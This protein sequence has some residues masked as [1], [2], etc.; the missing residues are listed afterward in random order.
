[1][2][3][4]I[5]LDDISVPDGRLIQAGLSHFGFYSGTM[6]GKPGPKTKDAYARYTRAQ[7]PACGESQPEPQ[8]PGMLLKY[9]NTVMDELTFPGN[10]A[11]G[12]KGR[13]A[14]RVQEWVTIN[15]F[16]TAID[17]NFG[18]ATARAVNDFQSARGLTV[19]T[20]GEVDR[21]TWDELVAPMARA[22]GKISPVD[23][24]GATLRTVAEQHLRE[25]PIE[26][27]GANCGPWVRAYMQ[28]HQGPAWPWCA[29][30]VNFVMKQA[31]QIHGITPPIPGS[32]SCDVLQAQA[33]KEGRFVAGSS[34]PNL[35]AVGLG[36]CSIFLVRRTSSDWTHTGFAMDMK[37][38]TFSTIEGNTNDKGSREGYEVCKRYRGVSKMDFIKLD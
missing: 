29:G 6:F 32:L 34:I 31:A 14:R 5:D 38:S 26:I 21:A 11:K 16:R 24:F 9:P 18:D 28:G 13:K 33:D 7:Q 3:T 27:G 36:E 25:H 22:F 4:I 12:A 10:V 1:M 15:G 23:T 30:F 37:S 2:S 19:T 17:E 20:D 8:Q 35:A